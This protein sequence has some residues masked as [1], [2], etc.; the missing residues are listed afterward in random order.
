MA[1]R[2]WKGLCIVTIIR[3]VTEMLEEHHQ[4]S[5][6]SESFSP[7]GEKNSNFGFVGRDAEWFGR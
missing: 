6:R 4:L 1:S 2:D 3:F 5:P 7:S